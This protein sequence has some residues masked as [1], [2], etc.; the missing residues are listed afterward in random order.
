M[1]TTRRGR[2]RSLLDEL[3]EESERFFGFKTSLFKF[4]RRSH[5]GLWSLIWHPQSYAD[6]EEEN[7]EEKFPG[8]I[9]SR[10]LVCALNK[11]IGHNQRRHILK[12]RLLQAIATAPLIAAGVLWPAIVAFLAERMEGVTVL[13]YATDAVVT[14]SAA[15]IGLCAA[16]V[17]LAASL[18]R[19]ALTHM[20][21][22]FSEVNA[23]SCQVLSNHMTKISA[24]IRG[25]SNKLLNIDITLSQNNLESIKHEDWPSKV[26][27]AF[28]LALW[29][30]K[31]I[32]SMERFWQLQLERLRRFEVLSDAAGNW[33]SRALAAGL[34][35]V[36]LAWIYLQHGGL[37]LHAGTVVLTLGAWYFGQLTRRRQYSFGM[38]EIV[39]QGFERNWSPFSSMRYYHNI[40]QQFRSSKGEYPHVQ[41]AHR[42]PWQH[43][44]PR[45][46]ALVDRFESAI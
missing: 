44:G 30:P 23:N 14:A 27:R 13:G 15:A 33:L 38:D 35:G 12:K 7:I 19:F 11:V 2:R 34:V 32:G 3:R 37:A 17:A 29:E 26:E 39:Q 1:S 18:M 41:A 20:M 43:R 21:H 42:L 46:N 45:A 28:K 6:L 22:A 25:I 5:R 10:A 36:A 40:A 9:Q 16:Y 24:R 4:H 8:D 31:R